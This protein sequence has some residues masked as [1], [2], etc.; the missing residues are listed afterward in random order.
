MYVCVYGC[1]CV[2]MYVYIYIYIYVCIY[3]LK[4]NEKARIAVPQN[5]RTNCLS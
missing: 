2:C 1:A 5:I 3:F 4:K